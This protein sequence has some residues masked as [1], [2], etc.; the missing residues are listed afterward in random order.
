MSETVGGTTKNP[1]FAPD[2]GGVVGRVGKTGKEATTGGE[3]GGWV[4]W[5]V[6]AAIR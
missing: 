6:Q 5:V 3:E 2:L 1:T 4:G